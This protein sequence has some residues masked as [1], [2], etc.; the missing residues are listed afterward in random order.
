MS[1]TYAKLRRAKEVGGRLATKLRSASYARQADSHRLT[2]TFYSVDLTESKWSSLRE[3]KPKTPVKCSYGIERGKEV[4]GHPGEM[5]SAVVNEFHPST[6]VPTYGAGRA[7]RSEDEKTEIRDQK[8]E[9]RKK[10]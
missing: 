3:K 10:I 6:I 5:R 4:G 1:A 2:R 8:A 9:G 7:G